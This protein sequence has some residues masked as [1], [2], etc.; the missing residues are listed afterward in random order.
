MELKRQALLVLAVANVIFTLGFGIIIPVLPY[1]SRNLGADAFMLGLLMASFSLMQFIF[2]PYWGQLSDRIGRKPVLA[3]G[4]IGFGLS[5]IIFGLASSLWMLFLSRIV[6]GILSAG[7]FPASFALIADV[8]EP[9]ERGK[10]M[11]W[12]GAA[13]GLGIIFGPAVCGVFV[14]FGISVPFFVAGALALVTVAAL[15][16]V[17]PESRAVTIDMHKQK[18]SLL[19]TL[20]TVW[21]SL[22][23]PLG[24]FFLLSMG[25]CFALSVYEG[26]FSYF[27][28]DKF[29]LTE[30][31]S[32]IAVLN[33]TMQST[34]PTVMAI[35]FTVMG[36]VSVLCQGV[37]VG[38]T[39][40]RLGEE[41]TTIVGLLLAAVGLVLV[42]VSPELVT[43]IISACLIGIGSGLVNPSI[44]SL[45][46][47]RTDSEKQGSTLGVLGS[48][49]SLG[50][51][52]GPPAGGWVYDMNLYMPYVSSA[53]LLVMGAVAVI[54]ISRGKKR[55]EDQAR[56]LIHESS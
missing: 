38:A 30:N 50:R 51:I 49:N 24:I 36:I 17:M 41:K 55:E 8:V 48:Y 5:F 19:S 32:M 27:I 18:A 11:G 52:V 46:S 13:S 7:I 23:T 31:P 40:K 15:Y 21:T 9:G 14:P 34:G 3:V 47:R 37:L 45:V 35:L 6:G 29:G 39:I 28:M 16:F 10:I 22:K 20:G 4:L 53:I 54:F 56:V 26:T 42:L 43:M 33:G 12:M 25:I 1:Y 2:A 44:S